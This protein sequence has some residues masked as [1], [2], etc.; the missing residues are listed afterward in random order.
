[1]LLQA[2][3]QL[4]WHWVSLGGAADVAHMCIQCVLPCGACVAFSQPPCSDSVAAL[5]EAPAELLSCSFCVRKERNPSVV[6]SDHALV[7]VTN[8]YLQ[9]HACSPWTGGHMV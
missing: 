3:V 5:L 8:V 2:A 9:D 6:P 7:C 4:R 1:M